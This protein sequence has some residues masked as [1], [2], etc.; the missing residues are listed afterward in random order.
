MYAG[1]LVE[2][3]R[4]KEVLAGPQHP[5]TQALVR[6]VLAPEPRRG[7]A[8]VEGIPGAPPDLRELPQGCAFAPRCGVALDRCRVEV[9]PRFR[10]G[11]RDAWCWRLLEEGWLP[12]PVAGRRGLPPGGRVRPWPR[13]RS[14]GRGEDRPGGGGWKGRGE[15]GGRKRGGGLLDAG[16]PGEGGVV[17]GGSKAGRVL[18]PPPGG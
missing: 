9:P 6:S 2:T 18:L 12:A 10:S 3:G 17:V 8:R 14:A 4:V 13:P 5:Y 15:P 11:D 7:R 1:R 16:E